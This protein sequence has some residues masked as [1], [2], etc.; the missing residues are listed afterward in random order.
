M[1]GRSVGYLVGAT[2]TV[3]FCVLLAA[4]GG[5]GAKVS[6]SAASLPKS[7]FQA[8]AGSAT[9][10]IARGES[11]TGAGAT[12]LEAT[13]ARYGNVLTDSQ[14]FVLYTYTADKPGSTGCEG[15][16]LRFWP[17]LLLP[18]G[19]A[20]PSAGP[21]VSGLGAF[22]RGSAI[23]VT[24]RGYPLYTYMTDRRPGQ[25]TGQGVVDGGGTWILATVAQAA[26]ATTTPSPS[27]K[28]SAPAVTSPVVTSPV[29][30]SPPPTS[31]MGTSPARTTPPP[32]SP[33]PTSP[34]TTRAVPPTSP[35]TT[36]HAPPTTAPVGGPTY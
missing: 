24:Y 5:G 9:T 23:Q 31:P 4:C 12:V 18:V 17:P 25:V 27:S 29:V 35:P 30:T 15:A 8:T 21:G 32:T 16:C 2:L 13:I 6:S 1:R 10:V 22:Q 3:A 19:V 33:P 34:P 14:G 28:S 20:H 26:V 11:A 36:R 7:P